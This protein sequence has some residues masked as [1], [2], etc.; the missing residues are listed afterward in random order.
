[1]QRAAP[2]LIPALW[3][4]WVCYWRI[5]SSDAKPTV[6]LES[7][8]SRAAHLVPLFLAAALLLMGTVPHGGLLFHRFVARGWIVYWVG[9]ALV[10]AG[11]GFA[12]WARVHLG[13]NWSASVTV[14]QGHELVRTG[15]YALVRHPIY[16]GLLL[17]LLGSALARGQWRGLLAVLLAL[18]G[19][20]YKLT[21]EERW[22]RETFGAA[23]D[24]Y[25]HHSRALIPYLL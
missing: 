18:A 4:A 13:R 12:V 17:A 11:L 2:Y 24:E 6:R 14:K 10:A 25:R 20:W 22:M 3:L 21:L 15:P 19:I 16:T 7:A 9:V 5:M 8:W 1:M 23:Y